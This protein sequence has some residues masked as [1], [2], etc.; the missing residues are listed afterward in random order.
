MKEIAKISVLTRLLVLTLFSCVIWAE[1][2]TFLPP[3]TKSL[4]L[5][6]KYLPT[7]DYEFIKIKGIEILLSPK[8]VQDKKLKTKT[9][10]RLSVQIAS[11]RRLLPNLKLAILKPIRIWVELDIKPMGYARYHAYQ[12]WLFE[13][14]Y[15]PDKYGG[16]EITNL[17]NYLNWSS[18][19]PLVSSVLIHELSHA[20]YHQLE[21]NQ[22]DQVSLAYNSAIKQKLYRNIYRLGTEQHGKPVTMNRAWALEDEWEYFSELSEAIFAK[23]DYFPHTAKELEKYDP[24]GYSLIKS[25]WK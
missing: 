24:K 2:K 22:K 3:Q 25:L 20:F 16:I 11:A 17:H 21:Q 5:P 8:I 7:P 15:N 1:E 4:S 6:T 9:I 18:K 19:D 23:N 13:N 10:K 14:D 12:E